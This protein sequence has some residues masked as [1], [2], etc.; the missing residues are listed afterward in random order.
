M[1][2]PPASD[3]PAQPHTNTSTE[4]HHS[5][6][7]QETS[8]ASERP[9]KRRRSSPD[10]ERE[11]VLASASGSASSGTQRRKAKRP[12]AR[13]TI[14]DETTE[15]SMR[16]DHTHEHR[17]R[18]S[19][20]G[21]SAN[22][23]SSPHSHTNGSAKSSNGESNGYHTN[24][25]TDGASAVIRHQPHDG[26][27]FH[28]HDREEVT[29]ILLQSLS[30]LGYHG[31]AKQLSGESGYELEIPSVAAFRSAVLGGEW[32]EAEAVLFGS[33]GGDEGAEGDGG[34]VMLGNG[35]SVAEWKRSRELVPSRN[36]HARRGLPLAESADTTFMRFM[37]RQ[38]KYLELLEN[39]DLNAALSVLRTELTPLKRDI[40]RLHALSSLVMCQSPDDLR[41]QAEWDGAQGES[42]NLLLS[43]LSRYIAPSVMIPEH[44]LATLFTAVQEEQIMNCRYHNTTAQPS[45]YQDHECPA[46]D[47]PLE[48]YL[49]LR[50]HTDEVWHLEF[51]HDGSM[52]ATAGKDGIV[53]VYD[54]ETFSLRHEIQEHNRNNHP[55]D[56]TKGVC[57]V[58]FSPNDEYLISCSQNNDFVVIS[59]RDGR[60]VAHADHFD[61]PV[62][63]AAWLP[64]SETFVIGTQ[65]S[66]RP[67][68]LYSIPGGNGTSSSSGMRNNEIHSWRDP[69]WDL[70]QKENR[71]SFRISDCAVS[72]DG[73][74][75]AATTLDHGIMVFDLRSRTKIAEWSLE[76]KLTSIHFSADGTQLLVSMNG[77][78][79][80]ALDSV[81]G[82]TIMRYEGAQQDK[83]VIRSS[84]GGAG[85]NFVISGSEDSRVLVWR[86]QTG[87]LVASLEAHVGGTVNAV[88]WSPTNHG[89]FASAG[90]DRR[91]RM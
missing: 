55:T 79:V 49:E 51:S 61:Y 25:H 23:G 84:F 37:L 42:R 45:L 13:D 89:M 7:V 54:T 27:P 63:T 70:S 11:V 32:E 33:S 60:R 44:R 19:T 43:D 12:R 48:T 35:H 41:R 17:A 52:L 87:C 10:P 30:D 69:P 74:R 68:G 2:P 15:P 77:G 40:A 24:G 26:T 62:T 47:F 1:S 46:D 58:A 76:D 14:T 64:D 85:E 78:R 18:Q 83:F 91:V 36:G 21:S 56:S 81:T 90:D 31:A 50:N 88:A 39:R 73:A 6:I 75:M 82:E 5:T 53:C 9:R 3:S 71:N 20:N 29:R 28:G 34:G 22:G 59:T 67:L 65:G 72:A 57:Y 86:R 4:V 80:L 38:Q 66:Q 8:E 16:L